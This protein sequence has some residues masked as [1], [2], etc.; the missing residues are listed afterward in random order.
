MGQPDLVET[1]ARLK[2]Y[3]QAGADCLYAQGIRTR[4]QIAPWLLPAPGPRLSSDGMVN[5]HLAEISKILHYAH[6][7]RWL[8]SMPPI[9]RLHKPATRVAWLTRE[10]AG[11]QLRELPEHLR[12]MAAFS[13]A[14]GLRETNVRLLCWQ[15]VDM[16]RRVAWI[17]ANQAK[18]AR[19]LNVPLNPEAIRVLG[20]QL[21]KH[22]R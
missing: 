1:I 5:R 3:A 4:E 21:G 6:L 2:A 13:L 8:D 10:Q 9:A 18:A 11:T 15:Q 22:T 7:R 12:S 19:D 20:H 16:R 17:Y 14:T